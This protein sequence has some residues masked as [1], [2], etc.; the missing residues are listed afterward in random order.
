MKNDM[1]DIMNDRRPFPSHEKKLEQ[2]SFANKQIS[3]FLCTL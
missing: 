1:N 3:V 2:N